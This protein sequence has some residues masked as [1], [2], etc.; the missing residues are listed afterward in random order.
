MNFSKLELLDILAEANE[1]QPENRML[2]YEALVSAAYRAETKSDSKEE[3]IALIKDFAE[4][5]TKTL[6]SSPNDFISECTDL[7]PEGHSLGASDLETRISWVASDPILEPSKQPL[8]SAAVG[9]FGD[10]TENAHA[11]VRLVALS[12]AGLLSKEFIATI[13]KLELEVSHG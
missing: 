8:V 12:E 11:W 4:V 10:G 9:K 13:S 2:K 7:L 6:S 3:V 5:S 1:M